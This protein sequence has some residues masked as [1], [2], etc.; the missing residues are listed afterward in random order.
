MNHVDTLRSTAATLRGMRVIRRSLVVR[1]FALF[2]RRLPLLRARPLGFSWAGRPFAARPIDVHG[3]VISVFV[4]REYDDLLARL[5]TDA[6]VVVDAG[7]N[8]GAF[9]MFIKSEFPAAKIV[10][11]EAGTDTYG[12]LSENVRRS[13]WNDWSALHCA[14]WDRDGTVD[15]ADDRQASA[16]SSVATDGNGAAVRRPIPARRLDALLAEVLP[17]TRISLLKLDI[18]GA[19][20]RVLDSVRGSMSM[21]DSLVIEVHARH[22]DEARVL[23]LLEEEF[24]SVE[25]LATSDD[26]ERVYFATR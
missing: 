12:I 2:G 21:I 17:D 20:E 24:A 10:S 7:A 3:S 9:A 8:V 5:S 4:L 25:R 13:G 19:E 15:F 18:E 16:N 22:V 1:L 6:P 14:I 11:V 26:D 23:A